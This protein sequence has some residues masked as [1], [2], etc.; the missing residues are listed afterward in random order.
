M[1]KF[2]CMNIGNCDLANTGEVFE[3]AEGEQEICPKC[4]STMIVE[5]KGGIP[6]KLVAAIGGVAALAAVIGG[7]AYFSG[8]SETPTPAAPATDTA[9]VVRVDSDSIKKGEAA[10][11]QAKE[12]SA[13]AAKEAEYAAQGKDDKKEGKDD[14]VDKPIKLQPT[15]YNLGYGRYEGPMSGGK[16]HGFGGSIT[17]TSRHTI[18]LKKASGETVE[19]GPGDKIMNVKMENGRLRQ[20]EIHFADGTRRF[21]SGL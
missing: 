19:V 2:K 17:V 1:K 12:D 13:K 7:I 10:A 20:G 5:A 15:S 9:L 14:E 21:I 8:G 11:L 6:T 4:G 18:D 3:I 16:P